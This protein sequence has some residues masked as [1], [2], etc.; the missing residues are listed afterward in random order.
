VHV[1]IVT[2][3]NL[4][5]VES[6]REAGKWYS[7]YANDTGAKCSCKGYLSHKHCKHLEAVHASLRETAGAIEPEED[8]IP[9]VSNL[10][11]STPPHYA[12]WVN[13]IHGKESIAYQGLLAMAHE[14][15]LQE[16]GAKFISVTPDL[17]LA[18]AWAKFQDGRQ[19]WECSDATP[20][21]VKAQV[22]AHYPR[23]ALT[24]AKARVLRDALNIGMVS[25]EELTE[26]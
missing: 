20:T 6:E 18:Y 5:E 1:R 21:N 16:L 9:N 3:P 19:F 25:M 22:K 24:R 8:H 2:A 17:A 26:E 11:V 7:V 14:R 15:G 13:V 12:K 10:V 4:Y 23:M